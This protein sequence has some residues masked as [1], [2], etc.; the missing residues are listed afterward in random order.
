MA[1]ATRRVG[2]SAL[3]VTVLGQGGA[4][5]GDLSRRADAAVR[6]GDRACALPIL[7]ETP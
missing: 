5:L 6:S 4:P 7:L 2:G 3:E 1:L